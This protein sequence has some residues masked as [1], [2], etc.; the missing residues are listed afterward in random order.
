MLA[1]KSKHLYTSSFHRH[2]T[3][4]E[5]SLTKPGGALFQLPCEIRDEIY[6]YCFN[7][8]YLV[9]WSYHEP[10]GHDKPSI[11][12]RAL[13][14]ISKVISFDAKDSLFSKAGS[15]ATLFKYDI[16]FGPKKTCSTPPRKEATDRMKNV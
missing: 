15:K 1:S 14:R 16:G 13:F 12:G 10:D 9:F 8:V 6:S 3:S 5:M 11:S 7:Q 2:D 4:S